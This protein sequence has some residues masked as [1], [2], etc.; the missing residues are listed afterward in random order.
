MKRILILSTV[1]AAG[2][3]GYMH[4]SHVR[5][6]DAA[7]GTPVTAATA[8]TQPAPAPIV[9]PQGSA[10]QVRINES[11]ST[12]R[13]RPGDRFDA[14]LTTPIVVDG[15][16]VAP[17]GTMLR[18]TV[19]EADRSGRLKG[20]AVLVVA[21][22]TIHLNNQDYTIDTSSQGR[23]SGGHKKRNFAWI[24]GG[25]GGGALIGAL[26]GGGVGAAIGAGAGAAAGVTG[27]VITGRKDVSIPAETRMTFRLTQ[28]VTLS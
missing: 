22:D 27:A 16:T 17:A 12:R 5:S 9:L 24:G 13:N 19:R 25:S 6:A 28:P 7:A 3:L 23:R 11:V 10:L 2:F 20:T 1:L 26:A 14:V 15:Q 21:L 18:G 4:I 8:V